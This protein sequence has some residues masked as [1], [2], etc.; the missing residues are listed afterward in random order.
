ML[1]AIEGSTVG[2]RKYSII[3]TG[4]VQCCALLLTVLV[5]SILYFKDFTRVNKWHEKLT[6]RTVG[7][8]QFLDNEKMEGAPMSF[9]RSTFREY[10]KRTK[11]R[12]KRFFW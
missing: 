10:G 5:H 4:T 12:K 1:E 7:W 6:R 2:L 9:D 11:L 3:E 8:L